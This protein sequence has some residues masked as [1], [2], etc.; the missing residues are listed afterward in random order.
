MSNGQ[1]CQTPLPP[2]MSEKGEWTE[3][4]EITFGTGEPHKLM[5]LVVR[6]EE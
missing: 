3:H 1:Q 6:R 4:A 5:E 2:R